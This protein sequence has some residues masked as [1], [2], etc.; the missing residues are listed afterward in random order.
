MTSHTVKGF[1]VRDNLLYD[2]GHHMWVEVL[3]EDRVR[4]GMDSL[5]VETSGTLAH[6]AIFEVGTTVTQG[7]AFGSLEAEK[8][9]GPLVA[10]L[11]GTITAVNTAAAGDPTLV[12]TQ[13][14]AQGWLIELDPSDFDAERSNLVSGEEAI[15]KRFAEKVTE[16]RLEG[17]LAE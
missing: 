12:H 17:V 6:L 5:G 9:V 11:S 13:P 1:E 10:P 14:Y 4:I 8:Y 2:V 16:Y 15:T 7:E 3:G